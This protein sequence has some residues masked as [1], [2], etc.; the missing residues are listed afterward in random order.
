M[1]ARTR[2]LL[3]A[4]FLIGAFSLLLAQESGS[5]KQVA[6]ISVTALQPD[7][8]I[9]H[10]GQPLGSFLRVTGMA[11]DGDETQRKEDAGQTL[12][13]IETVNDRTLAKPVYFTF[14]RAAEGI[15][16]PEAGTPFDYFVHEW[17]SFDGVVVPPQ[18]L[19]IESPNIA[20]DGFYYRRE[21]TIH[22]SN[23]VT[24]TP[25]RKRK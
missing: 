18:E 21:I 24:H 20:H 4:A 7:I 2:L 10:L 19:G 22:K 23:A 14:R 11:V 16:K 8:V 5:T 25:I 3:V 17:G 1:I 13:K 9:G 15:G 12:L 6:T